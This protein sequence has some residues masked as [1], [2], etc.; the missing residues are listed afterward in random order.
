LCTATIK[1]TEYKADE[2]KYEYQAATP[3]LAVFSEIYYDKGWNAYIDGKLLPHVRADYVLRSMIAPA[4]KHNITFKF[5]PESYYQGEKLAMAGSILLYL[6]VALGIFLQF[7]NN[8][9]SSVEKV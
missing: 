8:N 1:L 4:G 6:F 2:L 9:K 7:K 3:Q 5:E